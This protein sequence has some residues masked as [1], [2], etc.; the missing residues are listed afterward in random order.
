MKSG[1][2]TFEFVT[3]G[4]CTRPAVVVIGLA[5]DVSAQSVQDDMDLCHQARSRCRL[6]QLDVL[7]GNFRG[8]QLLYK[9]QD[10]RDS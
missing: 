3:L 6:V 1:K 9:V 7:V 8:F 2:G 5:A 10:N 4:C